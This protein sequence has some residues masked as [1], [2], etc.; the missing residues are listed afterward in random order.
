MERFVIASSP[1]RSRI[2]VNER[3]RGMTEGLS[4]D[5]TGKT[6]TVTVTFTVHEHSDDYLQSEQAISEE[7]ES[8]LESL[9]ATVHAVTVRP[10]SE[11]SGTS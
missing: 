7:F 6:Y 10:E 4:M 11:K 2:D 9:N 8:W 5:A 3:H 1:F